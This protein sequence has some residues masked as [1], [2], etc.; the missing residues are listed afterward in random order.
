MA[1]DQWGT[2]LGFILAAI[3]SAIGLG[4]IWRFPYV[5]ASNGGGAFLFPYFFA[6]IT[7]GIPI[8]I[9]EFTIGQKFKGGAPVALGKM[10]K[11]WEWLGWFQAAVAFFIATYYV[12]IVAWAISYIG[13]SATQAWG[14]DT[15]SFFFSQYLK[16]SEGPLNLGGIQL[17]I[18]IPF[19]AVWL[20]G[21]VI[22]SKGIKNGIEKANKVLIPT[23]I[24][25]TGVIVV[26]GLT[27]PGALDGLNYLFTPNWEMIRQPQVWVA[28]YSQIFFSLSI[29]FAIMIAYSSYLPEKTDLVNSAFITAFTNHGFEIF[30]ALGVFSV[31]GYMAGTQGVPVAEVAAAGPGLAF[32]VF[33]AA[34]SALPAFKGTVGVIFFTTLVFSGFTSFISII[35]AFTTGVIDKFNL[36][37][38][39]ALNLCMGCSFVISFAFVTGAGLYILD[40]L[41]YFINN[42]GI[43]LGGVLE[44]ILVGWFFDLEGLRT[45]ANRYSDFAVGKWWT[46]MIKFVT[47]L[48][49][50]FMF[51]QNFIQNIK[52]PYEG[53]PLN[54]L[55]M[56]GWGAF[57]LCFVFGFVFYLMKG[58]P[59]VMLQPGKE[60]VSK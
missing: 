54:A 25:L 59:S 22:L 16:L 5:C 45:H 3:G 31:L 44:V 36:S 46:Y 58:D 9:L 20:I 26:R 33:P 28:A 60:E 37:R 29:G 24:V 53:Y 2:R 6:I 55:L 47:P 35:E 43:V 10:N 49:L 42:F 15:K 32:V 41:D 8:L 40:I 1:R 17:H 21:Y 52:A 39:K 56:I 4:N 30:A 13:F 27:L 51:I 11:R 23:L 48:V 34:I 12:A 18:L 14:A 50:G 19:L 7:A 38:Q 57:A